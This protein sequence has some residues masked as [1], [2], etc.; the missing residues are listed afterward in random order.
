MKI[1]NIYMQMNGNKIRKQGKNLQCVFL[2][3]FERIKYPF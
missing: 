3:V 1:F 2:N